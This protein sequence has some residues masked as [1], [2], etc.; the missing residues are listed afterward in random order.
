MMAF[1]K[2]SRCHYWGFV[3]GLLAAVFVISS[4][5]ASVW[6]SGSSLRN[7]PGVYGTI[8]I[9]DVNN[10][11]GARSDS[12]CWID[13]SGNFWLFGG[14]GYDSSGSADALN[15]LWKYK[16]TTNE[17]AWVSGA[18]TVNQT[19]VYG[20]QGVPH[21]DN[22]PGARYEG[23]CW[24]DAS[25]NLWL[26]GGQGYDSST[27]GYLNDLWKFDGSNWTWV[28]GA[29]TVNQSGVYGTQGQA[30]PSNVPGAREESICWIDSSGDLWLF[31]GYGYDSSSSLGRLNDLWRFDVSSREWTW[32]RGSSTKNQQGVYGTKG[33][34]DPANVPGARGTSICWI[35]PNDSLW[36][37]GGFGYGSGASLGYL[38]DLWV[39]DITSTQWTWVSGSSSLNQTGFY[40]T[41][42][43]PN[44]NNVPGA[45]NES[46]S[47]ID[48][49]GD[50]W[51]FGGYGYDT[52]SFGWLNDLWTFDG[53]NWTWVAGSIARNQYGI[54]GTKAVP[55]LNNFPGSRRAGICWIDG[56]GDLW[57]FGGNGYDA[58]FALGRLN[59]LW[60]LQRF[61]QPPVGDLDGDCR[62][63][64]KDL[65]I[66]ALHW[67]ED[68]WHH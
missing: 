12:I 11:P 6:V 34:A 48:G 7:K 59:D 17:W 37:F 33:Q 22:V 24:T 15:D 60:K 50:L 56:S 2:I 35:D 23:V 9:P 53:S 58:V 67:L 31:G 5:E 36:L 61:C 51:L 42:G 13:G 8:G 1:P 16:L 63:D 52:S 44:S 10:V 47:W 57:L 46:I 54:Y 21:G 20:S 40:G 32:V 64:F 65:N 49:R 14:Y 62:V 66:M 55:D 4:A 3:A 19:G 39:F 45:R 25:D 68:T 30:H 43:E 27:F 38:N 28:K 26:F 41:Q 18:N 29:S